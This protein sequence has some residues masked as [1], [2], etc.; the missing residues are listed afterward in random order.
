M[1]ENKLKIRFIDNILNIISKKKYVCI[2]IQCKS[3][4]RFTIVEKLVIIF[5]KFSILCLMSN[6]ILI[7]DLN[8]LR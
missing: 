8:C 6:N 4:G 5:I 7:K 1:L 3:L 2:E